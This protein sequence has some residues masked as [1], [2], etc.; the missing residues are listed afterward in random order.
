MI[1]AGALAIALVASIAYLVVAPSTYEAEADLLV[2]PVPAEDPVLNSLGLLRESTD[3][4]RD[5]ETV[6][7][8]VETESVAARVREGLGLQVSTRSLLEDVEAEPVANSNLVAI[9]AQSTDPSQARDLANAFSQAYIDERTEEL[10]ALI[11]QRLPAARERADAIPS[12]TVA[13]DTAFAEVSTLE[14]LSEGQDPTAKA[15]I[16]ATTPENPVSPRPLLTLVGALLA[17]LVIGIGGA[18]ATQAID[19][20][21]RDESQLRRRYGIPI[22][23]RVPR[24]RGGDAP[25][26]PT[27]LSAPTLEA[28][29][30][31]RSAIMPRGARHGSTSILVTGASPSEGKTTTALNLAY[32]LSLAGNRVILIEADLRRPAIGPTV[33]V[34]PQQGVISVLLGNCRLEEALIP[35]P[36][37]GPSLQL[38]LADYK[39]EWIS[40][41]FSLPAARTLIEDAKEL[42]D[43]VVIDSPPLTA[44]VDALPLARYADRVLLVTKLGK[45]QLDKL[46]ELGELLDTNGIQPSGFA[47]LGTSRSTDAGS[48]YTA[49]KAARPSRGGPPVGRAATARSRGD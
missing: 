20:R 36:S 17:G 37:Q 8:L 18:F 7:A 13:S 26:D 38:L 22:L 2:Q 21:L 5:V 45:T 4:T 34:D 48:Y 1:V 27:A 14:T 16:E 44:V 6:A 11:E 9:T 10:Q 40:E 49:D 42:A 12:G 29:R 24:E 41:V 46:N 33:G 25:L 28:Y 15:E 32:A 47:L 30:T 3:A 35:S 31:L 19:R 43:F 23:A 39:G